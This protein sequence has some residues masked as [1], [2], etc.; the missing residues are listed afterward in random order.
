MLRT[1]PRLRWREPGSVDIDALFWAAARAFV[2]LTWFL[3]SLLLGSRIGDK[4]SSLASVCIYSLYV[5]C[6][7]T[8]ERGIPPQA[9]VSVYNPGIR[10]AVCKNRFN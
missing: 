9:L 5:V 2:Q 10:S 3:N 1:R 4:A 7:H 8:L 6:V